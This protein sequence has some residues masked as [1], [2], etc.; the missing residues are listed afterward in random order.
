MEKSQV[1][2]GDWSGAVHGQWVM[3]REKSGGIMPLEA[4]KA[5]PWKDN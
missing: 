5:C 3:W 1:L 4:I 2:I